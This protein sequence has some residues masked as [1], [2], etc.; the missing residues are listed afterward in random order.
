MRGSSGIE[1]DQGSK[2]L[3]LFTSEMAHETAACVICVEANQ[4][5]A[6]IVGIPK[7]QCADTMNV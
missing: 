7:S 5:F 6:K 3:G 4:A 1:M 2:T